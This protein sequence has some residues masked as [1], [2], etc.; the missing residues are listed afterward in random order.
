V[1][2]WNWLGLKPL[3]NNLDALYINLISGF[4]LDL[5]TAQLIRQHFRGPIYCDIH[6]LLLAVQPD[7]MRTL[8]PLP[9][10]A[11]W[12]RCFDL[13]QVNED[14]MS[15]MASDPMAL[16]AIAFAEGVSSIA[17]TLGAR[18]VVYFAAPGFDRISD[19]RRPV[20]GAAPGAIRTARMPAKIRRH[21]GPGDPIGCGDVW[22]ATYFSRLLAGD[23]L[24]AAIDRA[25]DA[26]ARNVDHR[27]ARG[28]ADYLR[29]E[30]SIK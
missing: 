19:L 28:L 25:L 20:L 22:G 14:E 26:A 1:P 21:T 8:R 16:A 24:D 4:E 23:N 12:C 17:V 6:S 11:A 27:G 29:G 3:L 15:M 18:G 10:P 5:E 9:N 2:A 7:G 30:L 13:I